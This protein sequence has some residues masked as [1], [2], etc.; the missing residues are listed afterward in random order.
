MVTDR[1][2]GI[3]PRDQQRIF[4]PFERLGTIPGA[5]GFGLGLWIARQLAH[6][7]GGDIRVRSEA[8]RGTAFTVELPRGGP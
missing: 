8:G 2:A 7:L 6:A 4:E 5:G 1:G 3:A